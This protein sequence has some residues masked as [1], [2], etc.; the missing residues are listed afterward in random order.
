[1]L[2]KVTS[3]LTIFMI[4]LGAY[5]ISLAGQKLSQTDFQKTLVSQGLLAESGQ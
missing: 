1:M 3:S 5:T 2:A 4:F